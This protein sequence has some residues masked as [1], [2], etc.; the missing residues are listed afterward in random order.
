[1]LITHEREKLIEAV[2]F[3]A[4][5]VRKLGKTKLFKLLYFLDFQHYRDTGRSVTGLHYSAWKM[6]PVPVSLFEELEPGVLWDGKVAFES[7]SWGGGEMLTPKALSAFDPKHFSRREIALLQGLA[8]DF[9]DADAETMIEKTHLENSPWH[10]VWEVQGARQAPIPYEL[11]LK[12]GNQEAMTALSAAR[13]ELIDAL[14][15]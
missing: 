5:N 9:R 13:Q 6:G 7:K 1:M 11:A 10:Q 2:A 8:K 3:F 15:R 12:K 14:S 4:A